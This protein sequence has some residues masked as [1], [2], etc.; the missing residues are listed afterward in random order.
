MAYITHTH[1]HMIHTKMVFVKRLS[2]QRGDHSAKD[3]CIHI[4]T[5][6]A[7]MHISLLQFKQPIA[8]CSL[9]CSSIALF[10]A[11]VEGSGTCLPVED[12]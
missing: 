9:I 12:D 7:C 10:Q 1:T 3:H 2:Q 8:Q 11:T 4:I 5:V 6:H